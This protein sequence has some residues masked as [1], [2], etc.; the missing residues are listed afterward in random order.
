MHVIASNIGQVAVGRF[1]FNTFGRYLLP[2]PMAEVDDGAHDDAI[3]IFAAKLLHKRFVDLDFV[4]GQAPQIGKRRLAD[5]KVVDCHAD[6]LI[7]EAA[8]H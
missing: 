2:Q 8:Q 1:V 3:R 5:A 7:S 4:H 6:S